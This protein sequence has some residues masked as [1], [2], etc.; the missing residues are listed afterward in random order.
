MSQSRK[1]QVVFPILL[2]CL[3]AWETYCRPRS[4]MAIRRRLSSASFVEQGRLQILRGA[5]TIKSRFR[6]LEQIL[7]QLFLVE[8]RMK[9]LASALLARIVV[10]AI[11]M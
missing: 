10:I 8:G 11:T 2:E 4:T 5:C 7:H 3:H 9:T 6:V 1:I